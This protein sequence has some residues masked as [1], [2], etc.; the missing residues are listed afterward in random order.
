MRPAWCVVRGEVRCDA[1][2]SGHLSWP[3]RAAAGT[4]GTAAAA[5]V[6]LEVRHLGTYQAGSANPASVPSGYQAL[7][8]IWML[9]VKHR[10]W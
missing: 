6:K 9:P 5:E 7:N 1:A 3:Y 2:S 8:H 4:G 10:V